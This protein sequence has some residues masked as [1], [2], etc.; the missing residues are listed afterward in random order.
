MENLSYFVVKSVLS[1]FTHCCVEKKVSKNYLVEK[2]MINMRSAILVIFKRLLWNDDVLFS[3]GP[4]TQ[5]GW[6]GPRGRGRSLVPKTIPSHV[7]KAAGLV[8]IFLGHNSTI[9][10]KVWI[11]CGVWKILSS[12]PLFYSRRHWALHGMTWLPS[13]RSSLS[14]YFGG[15]W[16]AI[17]QHCNVWLQ[18]NLTI[19]T[20]SNLFW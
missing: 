12:L 19:L 6:V 9:F 5:F 3:V 16:T 8:H 2:K 1:Q 7:F 11:L 13:L 4:S 14:K 15:Q 10:Q 20:N 18:D 17:L